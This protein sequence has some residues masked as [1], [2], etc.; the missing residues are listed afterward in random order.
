MSTIWR[1]TGLHTDTHTHRHT[2]T[3]ILHLILQYVDT[4]TYSCLTSYRR[5]GRGALNSRGGRLTALCAAYCSLF[6]DSIQQ[7]K[8]GEMLSCRSVSD[9]LSKK[10]KKAL[11]SPY[12]LRGGVGTQEENHTVYQ[13]PACAAAELFT[14]PPRLVSSRPTTTTL[15]RLW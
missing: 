12:S 5:R 4:Y 10:I 15:A 6:G 2:H 14:R 13:A 9:C 8:A 3:L 1:D 11:P 7:T